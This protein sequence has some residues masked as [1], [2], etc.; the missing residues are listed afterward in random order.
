M[1]IKQVVNDNGVIG[2]AHDEGVVE[3]TRQRGTWRRKIGKGS[4]R[5]TS[6]RCPRSVLTLASQPLVL[7]KLNDL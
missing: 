2:A 6:E 7:V 4:R 3:G 5:S 1:V